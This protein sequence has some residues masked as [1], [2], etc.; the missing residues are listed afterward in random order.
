[1]GNVS[2]IP[3]EGVPHRKSSA[4]FVVWVSAFLALYVLSVGPACRLEESKKLPLRYL[5][6]F[7]APLVLLTANFTPTETFLEWYVGQ[8]E[9]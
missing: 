6:I 1:V 7:Y 4:R 9:R 3:E 2:E 8:W 5:E